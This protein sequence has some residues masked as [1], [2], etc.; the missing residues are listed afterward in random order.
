MHDLQI[1]SESRVMSFRH[2]RLTVQCI[3]PKKSWAAI[4]HV[5][6]IIAKAFRL[7]PVEADYLVSYD[8]EYRLG[9]STDA[10]DD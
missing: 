3:L 4:Q 5:D 2:D 1:N 7:A 10:N 8:I 6:E 9:Q